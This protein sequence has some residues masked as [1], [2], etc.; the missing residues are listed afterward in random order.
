MQDK[1]R[2]VPLENRSLKWESFSSSTL[3]PPPGI[4]PAPAPALRQWLSMQEVP[5]AVPRTGRCELSRCQSWAGSRR[6]V[7]ELLSCLL[8][9]AVRLPLCPQPERF[10]WDS[11]GAGSSQEW[12]ASCHLPSLAATCPWVLCSPEAETEERVWRQ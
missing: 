10:R 3:T 8:P 4:V 12:L 2:C 1:V 7:I 6:Q 11:D 5:L 9:K